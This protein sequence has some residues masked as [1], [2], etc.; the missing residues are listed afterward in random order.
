M[1]KEAYTMIASLV[2]VGSM[3]VA[4][5]SQSASHTEIRAN[6]PFEFNVGNK[7]LAAGEYTIRQVNPSCDVVI[8]EIRNAR[9]GDNVLLRVSTT[10]MGTAN[11]STVAF[12]RYG[13]HYFFSTAKIE[14]LAD[15]WQAPKSRAERGIERELA[16]LK[17]NREL[18]TIAAR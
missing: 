2:L 17:A 14:G 4:A 18:V 1:K 15:A 6:I 12:K 8:L 11:S 13:T 10:Q 5:Q 9:S 3:A 7:T 16:A